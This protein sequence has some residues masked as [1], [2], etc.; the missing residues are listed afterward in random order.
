MHRPNLPVN[1]SREK[2]S[3]MDGSVTPLQFPVAAPPRPGEMLS[4]APGVWWLRMPLPF[5]LDHINLWLLED[6]AGWTIV[7]TGY[8]TARTKELWEQ[9]FA[10]GLGGLPVARIIVTHYHPDHIGLAGWLTERWQAPLWITEKEWLFARVMS[11]AADDFIPLRR[12]FAHRAGLGP[13]ASEL[14]G[15]REQSYR[16]GVPEVPASFQRLGDGMVIEIGGREWRVIVG[17]G[18]APELA[19]LYC[20]ETGVLIA[21][22]QVLPK[23][24]PNVSVQ[25][26]EPDGDPLAR[27]LSSLCKLQDVVPPDALVLPSHNLPFLGLHARL[28]SLAAHHRA[29][30]DEVIAA[31]GTPKAAVEL[32][33]VLFRRSLDRHQMGFALGEALAHLHYLMHQ[34]ILD[35][36]LD[37]DGVNH[38]TRVGN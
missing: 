18:H 27:F 13:A 31:C 34:G 17:E 2:A 8:A 28:E 1:S 9:I 25:A 10:E 30:C 20:A 24:S 38:F 36:V 4:I 23:I 29:R 22:D 11:Q 21:G 35:R 7:D 12:G 16:R 26:H 19:C 32:L 5:A 3:L 37:A 14:F 15:E 33:P 6:G